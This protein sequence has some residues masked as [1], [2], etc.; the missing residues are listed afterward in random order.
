MLRNRLAYLK[1]PAGLSRDKNI[2]TTPT[3]PRAQGINT[4]AF[5]SGV[6]GA[7]GDC[8]RI[9]N[10]GFLDHHLRRRMALFHASVMHHARSAFRPGR[11][12]VLKIWPL[13]FLH[14]S[15]APLT[16]SHESCGN[17]TVPPWNTTTKDGGSPADEAWKARRLLHAEQWGKRLDGQ[18]DRSQ[19]AWGEHGRAF[20]LPFR[21]GV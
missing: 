19:T 15:P 6:S 14:V 8:Y 13:P 12:P 20:G 17:V 16:K 4:Q 9:S 21:A 11:Q 2:R 18:Q 1:R 3:R 7:R 5:V 10:V